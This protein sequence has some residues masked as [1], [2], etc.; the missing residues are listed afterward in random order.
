MSTADREIVITR[1]FDAPRELTWQAMMDPDHV[2]QWWGPNGF[3]T[4]IQ[5]MDVRPGGAWTLVMH[6]PDGTDYPN[7]STF[8]EIVYPERIVYT[9]GGGKAGGPDA[10][11]VA[12]W[13]F[14]AVEPTKTRLTVHMLFPSAAARDIVVREYG[15]IEGGKQT[16]QRL[17]E[18]LPRM[19]FDAR[20]VVIEREVNASPALV[21][22]CWTDPNHLARWWGPHGFSNPVCEADPRVGG[23]WRIV[24]R[25]PDG[26]EYPCGGTYLEVVQ[27]RRL[28][29]TNIATDAT[30]K[31]VLEGLTT[32]NFAEVNGKTKLTVDTRATAVMPHAVQFLQG[33]H[34]GWTQSLERLDVEAA[35]AR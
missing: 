17:S 26:T 25:A 30:G 2:V 14:E 32:V 21:F 13:T 7:F 11:F 23:S 6:G 18:H 33:M 29:F 10:Q 19:G 20:R 9:H 35:T 4:T 28:V 3:T 24:M 31:P 15:A 1:V 16:F 12:T 22:Q 34:A 8:Q 5:E 27:D